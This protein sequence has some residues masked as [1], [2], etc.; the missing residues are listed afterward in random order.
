MPIPAQADVKSILSDFEDRLRGVVDAAWQEWLELPNRARFVFL[1]R[2]RA[3]M[4]FDFIARNAIS[5]FDGD[6][7]IVVLIKCRQTVHF[8]FN[9]TVLLRFKLGNSKGVGSNIETQAVMDFIDPQG[10]IPGLVPD[11]MKVEVCYSP[12]H[13]GLDLADVAQQAA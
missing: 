1:P 13:L 6:K 9:D 8:L 11:I 7:N 4:V 3:V 2:V 10:V 5:E 12:D